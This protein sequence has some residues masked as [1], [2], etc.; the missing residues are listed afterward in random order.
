MLAGIKRRL[1]AKRAR[2]AAADRELAAHVWK[3][4]R[5]IVSELAGPLEEAGAV[6]IDWGEPASSDYATGISLNPS[7]PGAAPVWVDA[8]PDWITLT[9]G[10]GALE[11]LIDSDGKWEDELTEYIRA[12]A[13]GRYRESCVDGWLGRRIKMAFVLADG[14]ECGATYGATGAAGGDELPLGER[15][16]VPYA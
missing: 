2:A 6:R 7:R 11:I 10:E 16:Y 4:S 14:R 1:A 13:E 12:V 8:A 3:R 9:T 5:E 15:R